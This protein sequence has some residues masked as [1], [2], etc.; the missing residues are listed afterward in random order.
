MS[1]AAVPGTPRRGMPGRRLWRC[2]LVEV[3]PFWRQVLV[4]LVLDLLA[5]PLLL[6]SPVPIKIA[7]DNVLGDKPLP[8]YVD[9][10]LPDAVSGSDR[11]LFVAAVLQVVVVLL[12]QLQQLLSY[13][14][15]LPDASSGREPRRLRRGGPRPGPSRT[16]APRRACRPR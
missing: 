13:G 3:R 7:V 10:L 6:L 16:R 5:T 11:L 1:A 14:L 9:R 15:R 8:S 2:L 12:F 4:I